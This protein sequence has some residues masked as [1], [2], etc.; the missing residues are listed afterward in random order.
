MKKILIFSLLFVSALSF[1]SCKDDDD[2]TPKG[3]V[4][5]RLARPSFRCDNNT[6]KG[7]TDPYNSV[8]TDY[9]TANLYWFIVNDAVAYEIMWTTPV[10]YVADGDTGWKQT[11]NNED[12]KYLHGHVVVADKSAITSSSRI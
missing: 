5:D 3:G 7:S 6:G 2:S 8:I 4:T 10:A 9:N 12:G 11:M 1:W